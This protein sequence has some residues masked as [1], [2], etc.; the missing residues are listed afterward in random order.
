MVN[1]PLLNR[2]WP[3]TVKLRALTA[4]T[5]II[6]SLVKDD[7]AAPIMSTDLM[8]PCAP[9]SNEAYQIWREE[10]ALQ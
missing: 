8:H 1:K 2:D 9:T 7:I 3:A 5:F 10:N 6:S 4:P